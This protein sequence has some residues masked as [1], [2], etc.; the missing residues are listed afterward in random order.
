MAS[1]GHTPVKCHEP[2]VVAFARSFSHVDLD[3][4]GRNTFPV[5]QHWT[6]NER[7]VC[8]VYVV[9]TWAGSEIKD[10]LVIC[11]HTRTGTYFSA[12]S[13]VAWTPGVLPNH[14]PEFPMKM[15]SYTMTALLITQDT[16]QWALGLRIHYIQYKT[17]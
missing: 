13:A 9:Y 10:V 5:V 8:R 4:A 1:V 3:L 7:V 6:H 12:Q 15:F 17:H 11:K 2:T 14:R 16:G